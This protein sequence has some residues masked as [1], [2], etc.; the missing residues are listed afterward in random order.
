MKFDF[1][2]EPFFD[3]HTH[4]L[5]TDKTEVTVDEFIANY[6]HGIIAY[7]PES[8][9]HLP[10]QGVV[11]TLVH[12][13]A[14][15]LG[16]EETLEAVVAKRNE[17]TKTP[18]LLQEY[19]RKMYADENIVGTI[20]DC[21]LPMGHPDTACFPC[22]TYRLFQFEKV[23]FKLLESEESYEVFLEKLLQS[24]RT[25]AAEGFSGL[26]G[27]I[28]ERYTL[29][30]YEVDAETASKQFAAAKAG[31]KTA[32]KEVYFAAFGEILVL[33]AELGIPMHIHTGCTGMGK[34][35]DVHG[36]DPVLMADFLANPRYRDSKLLLLHG[37]YPMIRN[38]AIM[39]FNFPN[40]YVD[41]SQT[42]PW[43]AMGLSNMLEDLLAVAPHD[44]IIIGSGQHF[45]S[46]TAWLASKTTKAAL[47]WSM[48]KLV[49]QG[50]LSE[51]QAYASA[52]MIL[53]E[54]ALKL[55]EK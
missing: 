24:I 21:E 51:E 2:K 35:R 34:F 49:S 17:L 8:K 44:K 54:N 13:M 43:D 32:E 11:L 42:V 30:V 18:E 7:K 1:H 6:Y 46:E 53:S 9:E 52:R 26:K 3:N 40:V 36:M 14:E 22:K 29:N 10:Y 31:D 12:A 28:A 4:L 45:Y 38:S 33:C 55:Y 47:E 48:E 20:L 23:L 5:L 19:T 25:A 15:Y 39:A 37:S 27:H 16:C 50:L 41:L